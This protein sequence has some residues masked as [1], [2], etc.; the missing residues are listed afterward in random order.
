MSEDAIPSGPW[1]VYDGDCPFC[2]RYVEYVETL[3]AVPG[4]RLISARTSRPEVAA[5]LA[6][7]FDLDRVMVLRLDGRWFAGEAAMS[8]LAGRAQRHS[9]RN[10]LVARILGLPLVGRWLYR[11]LA[12]GRLLTLRLLG[13]GRIM[14]R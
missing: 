14:R 8:E 5:A 9:R 12:A 7:G 1:L 3:A 4:L 11:L 13:R 10:R 6:A 2:S